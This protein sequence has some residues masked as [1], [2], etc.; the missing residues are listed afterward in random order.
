MARAAKN[1]TGNTEKVEPSKA[2]INKENLREALI[3]FTY[4]KPYRWKFA[5]GLVFI[6]LSAFSTSVFPFLIGKMIDAAVPGAS[7]SLPIGNT[8]LS[9]N[10]GFD[11]K[12][13][14]WSL[15]TIIGLIFLQLTVQMVFSFMRVYLLTEVGEKSLADMRRD[16]Y[17][18]LISMP[19]SF[20]TE[21]RVGELSSRISS[22]LSQ[23]QD[24][25]SFSLAELLR[26]VFTLLIGLVFI[27]VISTKL[28]LVMLSVVPVIAILAVVYGKRIRRMSKKAQDQLAESGTIVQENIPGNI[29]RKI[30]HQRVLRN[31]QVHQ[32]YFFRRGYC[33]QECTIPGAFVSFMIFSVF[34]TIAFV[35]WYGA[36]MIKS[37][38]LTAGLLTMFVIFS[39][40]VG[41]T[42]A[43]FADMFSQLQKTLGATHSVREILRSEGEEVDLENKKVEESNRLAGSVQFD[44]VAFTYPSR[45]DVMVLKDVSFN[46]EAG[47]QIALVGPS[48]AGKSTIAS[49]LLRFYEPQSGTIHFDERPAQSI[50]ISQLRKQLAFVPQDVVL[51]GGTI[52]ENIAYGKPDATDE[53]IADAAIKA[54]ADEF[55]NRFP[56]RYATIVGERGVKT[57][58]G[59]AAKDRHCKSDTEG[60]CQSLS[61]MKP[62]VHLTVKANF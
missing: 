13:V 55:I 59:P 52:R 36:N 44:H 45:P 56:E 30:I 31:C 42:F 58:R 47:E 12:E 18:K 40:F 1:N 7:E 20:F 14:N 33:H 2:K 15:N 46:A 10:L 35:M 3:L 62:P 37:G 24:A 21:K 19:M 41:G 48:G 39:V 6:A 29:H 23:I 5:L 17:K 49:L 60:S 53:E 57:F 51:F 8:G 4:L 26:G 50:P 16:V 22:D 38:E 9:Q 54:H 11:I 27:F 34:G 32:K 43:G 28:A 61:W 25:I